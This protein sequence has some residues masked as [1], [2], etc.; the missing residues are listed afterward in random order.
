M[1]NTLEHLTPNQK[2]ELDQFVL[3]VK[4]EIPTDKII[5]YGSRLKSKTSLGCFFNDGNSNYHLECDLLLILKEECKWLIHEI[6]DILDKQENE[7]IS[8]TFIIYRLNTV[9]EAILIGNRFFVNIQRK[10]LPLYDSTDQLLFQS[11]VNI[12]LADW[13]LV[14]ENDWERLHKKAIDFLKGAGFYKGQQNFEYCVF[15]LHQSIEQIAAAL[16]L[17]IVGYRHSLHNTYR[18]I[19]LLQQVGL[20]AAKLFPANTA[21]EKEIFSVLR[22]SYGDA[23]YNKDYTVSKEMAGVIYGRVKQLIKDAESV[24]QWHK[25]RWQEKLRNESSTLSAVVVNS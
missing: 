21:E 18:I 14:A 10:G 24:Y 7:Y 12:E 16:L 22:Y 11:A 1:L 9:N 13:V 6:L 19:K 17:S 8:A 4:T 25:E 23:R 3:N 2:M 5:C 15:L 20:D